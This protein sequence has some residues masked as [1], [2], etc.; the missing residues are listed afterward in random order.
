MAVN[1]PAP[2]SVI[3]MGCLY[4]TF[5]VITFSP[6]S[7]FFGCFIIFFL[8]LESPI[9]RLQILRIHKSPPN[10]IAS[11]YFTPFRLLLCDSESCA[12]G[13]CILGNCPDLRPVT[14][15]YSRLR[16]ITGSP[17]KTQTSGKIGLCNS[18][19][20]T[21]LGVHNTKGLYRKIQSFCRLRDEVFR[22][23]TGFSTAEADHRPACAVWGVRGAPCCRTAAEV[24][25]REEQDVA[26]R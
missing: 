10:N 12:Q 7:I 20:R 5:S 18:L 24:Q 17:R 3:I 14:R 1:E 6:P 25:E 21:V 13:C 22:D 8:Y 9:V 11:H 19:S 15:T 4:C 23:Q 16:P 26:G 2:Y